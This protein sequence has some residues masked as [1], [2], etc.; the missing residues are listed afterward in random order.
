MELI[1]IAVARSTWN[2][3]IAELNC[4][5]MRLYPDVMDRIREHYDF[6]EEEDPPKGEDRF[7]LANG[8]HQIPQGDIVAIIALQFFADGISA[9]TR[10]HTDASDAF[11]EDLF[12][13]LKS[14]LGMYYHKNLIRQKTYQ[15]ELSV[16]SNVALGAVCEKLQRFAERLSTVSLFGK[17][18]QQELAS[19]YFGASGGTFSSFSFERKATTPFRENRFYCRAPLTTTEHFRLLQEF[20]NI[21]G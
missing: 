18:E 16:R 20:E 12:G 5:G 14:D 2:L 17:T 15:S 7:K 9:E 10:A 8:R 4:K 11:L 6:D 19:I 1:S 3:D 21:I 13:W